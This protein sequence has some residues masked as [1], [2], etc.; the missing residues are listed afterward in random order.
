MRFFLYGKFSSTWFRPDE[1]GDSSDR[2]LKVA[3]LRHKR[4]GLTKKFQ[5]EYAFFPGKR[6]N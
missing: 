5:T 1:M 2:R 3:A 4:N 6:G